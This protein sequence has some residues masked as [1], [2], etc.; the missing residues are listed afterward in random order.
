ML[1]VGGGQAGLT[2]AATLG[3]L[4]VDT[5]VIDRHERVGDNQGNCI[6]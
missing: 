1:V 2:L 6:K 3:H 5:L 4:G